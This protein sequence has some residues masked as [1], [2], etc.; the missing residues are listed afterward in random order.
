MCLV[1]AV[2]DLDDEGEAEGS[3]PGSTAALNI[4]AG[5]SLP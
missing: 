3:G 4:L 5:L 1:P 2:G